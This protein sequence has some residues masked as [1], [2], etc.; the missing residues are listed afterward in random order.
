MSLINAGKLYPALDSIPG[1]FCPPVFKPDARY[2]VN[3]RIITAASREVFSPIQFHSGQGVQ[4]YC[5]GVTPWLEPDEAMEALLAAETAYD[6]GLGEWPQMPVSERI[7]CVEE[8]LQRMRPLEE[9]FVLRAMWEIG[10]SYQACKDEFKRT[11]KYAEDTVARLRQDDRNSS[12][13]QQLDGFEAQIRRC[14]LGPTLLMGPFNYPLNES[15][16]MLVP[17]LVMGNTVVM[18]L[19]AWGAWA[20]EP[21]LDA[22][23]ESFPPGVVNIINGDGAAIITPIIRRGTV[24]ILGFIGSTRVAHSIVGQHPHINRM[25]TILG[26]EAKNPAFIF[27]D[28]DL[29]LTVRECLQGALEYNG[30]RCTALKHL[31]VHKD[32]LDRFLTALNEAV[33]QVKCGLPWE[34]EVMITPLAEKDKCARLSDWIDQAYSHGARIVNPGGGEHAGNLFYPAVLYPVTSNMD[35]FHVEQFG[36]II[37]VSCF[38]ALDEIAAYMAQCPYGQQASIFTR[39]P[40]L[41]A[42]LIDI[43]VTQVSRINL[44]AQCRR[45][46][47]DL[48]FTGRKDSAEGTLSVE[49]ALRSFS[50]RAL[51]V[52]NQSG[53]ELFEAI[54]DKGNSKF[55]RR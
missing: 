54:L 9:E 42:P 6:A 51:V 20:L 12:L 26:L 8:L 33:G 7:L 53:Q 48:P 19:P 14:P 37:P 28:C 34:K 16:A 29:E 15:F 35:L 18:K 1:E 4:P 41:A 13:V 31:W 43:L 45:G 25:R 52:A 22:L 3:G 21:F 44:N 46:P 40:A 5:L 23:C 30:Q 36:P 10:K 2:L 38:A 11:I 49:D 24:N 27:P 47:D 39:S 32:I 55:L 50:I 17:A